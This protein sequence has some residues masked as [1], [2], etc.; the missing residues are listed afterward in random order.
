MPSK[1]RVSSGYVLPWYEGS[2]LTSL[3]NQNSAH[4][5]YDL[6]LGPQ[7]LGVIAPDSE[8]LERRSKRPPTVSKSV[9]H[10]G[11][12]LW[13]CGSLYNPILFEHMQLLP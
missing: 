2:A 6:D 8:G 13:E 10:S 5:A 3:P 12:Y 7:A 9:F 4:T 1:N 11:G